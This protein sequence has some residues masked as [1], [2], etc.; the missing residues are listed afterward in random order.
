M[1]HSVRQ[2]FLLNMSGIT[3]KNQ[4]TTLLCVLMQELEKCLRKNQSSKNVQY[5]EHHQTLT[6]LPLAREWLGVAVAAISMMP[7]TCVFLCAH[8]ILTI[9]L[10]VGLSEGQSLEKACRRLIVTQ[11]I[12]CGN[13]NVLFTAH[14][15]SSHHMI[16]NNVLCIKSCFPEGEK[17]STTP[18][19]M[20]SI[21]HTF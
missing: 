14:Q 8:K 4:T 7:L 3:W 10:L 2:C 21:S 6:N 12:Y 17:H 16:R 5:L 11:N 20:L 13:P 9:F 18:E 1:E 15:I 19:S